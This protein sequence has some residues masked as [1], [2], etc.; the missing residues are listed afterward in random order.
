MKRWYWLLALLLPAPAEG[1]PAF[2]RIVNH[3]QLKNLPGIIETPGNKEKS[4]VD[5]LK[6][7]RDLVK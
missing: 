7:L 4:E 3:P 5:D 6:I 1:L 2:G